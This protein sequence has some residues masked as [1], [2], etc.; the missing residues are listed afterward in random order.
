MI[1]GEKI[2]IPLI[3]P[4]TPPVARSDQEFEANPAVA[5]REGKQHRHRFAKMQSTLSR[6]FFS[7]ACP[8]GGGVPTN[9]SH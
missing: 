4:W 1:E 2:P 5:T 8:P 7:R 3:T 6:S 9:N